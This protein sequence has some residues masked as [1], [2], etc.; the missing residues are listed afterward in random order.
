MSCVVENKP[1]A[2]SE[3]GDAITVR[4][5]QEAMP[6][7]RVTIFYLCL[8]RKRRQPGNLRFTGPKRRF[9]HPSDRRNAFAETLRKATADNLNDTRGDVNALMP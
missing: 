9:R 4:F 2:A 8:D 7:S 3:S 6:P 1:P 5:G